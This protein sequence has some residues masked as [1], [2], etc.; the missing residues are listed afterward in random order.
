MMTALIAMSI[1]TPDAV[2]P[3]FD[4]PPQNMREYDPEWG[5]AFYAGTATVNCDHAHM[6]A[7]ARAPVLFTHHYRAIDPGT[8][9]VV[10]AVSDQQVDRARELV[11]HAGQPFEIM[12]FPGMAH[13]MHGQDPQ[14]FTRT[15][16]G[17]S[18]TIPPDR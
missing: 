18:Q 4:E 1:K 15:V 8:G 6:L 17:W 10:G 9:T 16:A 3:S 2:P 14:L 5:R 12:S 7:S 13:S 11:T